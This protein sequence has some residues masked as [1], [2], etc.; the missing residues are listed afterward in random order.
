MLSGRR[1]APRPISPVLESEWADILYVEERYLV[2]VVRLLEDWNV[3]A[4]YGWIA[5]CQVN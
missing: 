4:D 2:Y 5:H 1:F 3:E